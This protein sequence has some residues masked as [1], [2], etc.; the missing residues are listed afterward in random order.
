MLDSELYENDFENSW[1]P[2]CGNF[3]LRNALKKAFVASDITPNEV[4]VVSGIGQAA[5]MPHY[6][7]C[8]FFNGLHGRA[9]PPAQAIRIA[10][11]DLQVVVTTGDGD[12]YGEGGN[13]FLHAIRRNLNITVIVH[14]NQI[15]GLTKGQGS[16]TT[17]FGQITPMQIHGV[18]S[19][20]MNPIALAVSQGCGFVARG[21]IGEE[22]HLVHLIRQGIAYN[23]F[24]LI[25][26]LQP[27][28]SFNKVNTFAWYAKRCEKISEE[29][30]YSDINAAFKLSLEFGDSGIPIGVIYRND[31]LQ[32][33]EEVHNVM[34]NLTEP[35]A[36]MKRCPQDVLPF[37]KEFI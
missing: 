1:C 33:F 12:C 15:Y 16:P 8:N 31:K 28:V 34:M 13:H 32:P 21:F 5:K 30:D 37:L 29:H 26:V 23:G 19:M 36:E 35:L 27:C 4:V 22:E 14:D 6:M 3:P 7:N 9:L 11:P 25:D 2:G 10:D 20:P 18:A 17:A 24:A